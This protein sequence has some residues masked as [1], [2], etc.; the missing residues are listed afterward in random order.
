MAVHRSTVRNKENSFFIKVQL[1]ADDVPKASSK[2]LKNLSSFKLS[3]SFVSLYKYR[4]KWYLTSAD[5]NFFLN[6]SS[7]RCRAGDEGGLAPL[8]YIRRDN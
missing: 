4:N 5:F 2:I 3:K 7:S 1:S 6:T 8:K